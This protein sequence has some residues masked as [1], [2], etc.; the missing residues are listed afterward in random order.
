MLTLIE[1]PRRRRRRGLGPL[2]IC[3]ALADLVV[4][5]VAYAIWASL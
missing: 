1:C 5:A 4:L 2:L 3:G